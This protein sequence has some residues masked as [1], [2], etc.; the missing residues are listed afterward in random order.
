MLFLVVPVVD[1][2]LLVTVGDRIGFWPTVGTV[3]ATAVVGSAL[4]RREGLAAWRRVQAA[5]AGGEAPGTAV[6]DGLV[7]LIAGT[8][9]LTPGF[10]TDLV[11]LLGLVPASRRVL[12]T[13]LAARFQG[14]LAR[15]TIRTAAFGMGA[16]PGAPRSPG[17]E[18]AEVLSDVA[19]PREPS[20]ASG[21]TP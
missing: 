6:L 5:L 9:L 1:L 3:V 21:P 4:A 15:G 2:A 14:A 19:L 7:V 10:I 20:E 8:L 18:D 17:V 11:G 13:A 12:R 16:S